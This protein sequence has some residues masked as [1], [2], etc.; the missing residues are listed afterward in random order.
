MPDGTETA[1]GRGFR[2]DRG[3]DPAEPVADA[4]RMLEAAALARP[5]HDGEAF[6]AELRTWASARGADPQVEASPRGR[7]RRLS[8]RLRR[9]S[10]EDRGVERRIDIPAETTTTVAGR[11][12]L[13]GEQ[14]RQRHRAARLGDDP[15]MAR[16][17]AIAA[18]TSASVT[19][20]PG[21]PASRSAPRVSGETS[22]VWRA[23]QRVGGAG[24]PTGTGWPAASERA[25]SSQPSGSTVD[26]PRSRA[27]RA[28]FRPTARR[29]RRGPAP[30][31]ARAPSCS[32]DLDADAPL[33]LD[34]VDIVERGDQGRPALLGEAGGDLLAALGGA[35]V[36]DDLGARGAR[37]VDASPPARRR[38]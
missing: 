6:A 22:L 16:A 36:E 29:R 2:A 17:K 35:V 11:A 27:A 9:L 4:R 13:A 12:R 18:S 31:R 24:S 3:D 38:A 8:L 20:T 1:A 7:S 25:M 19:A 37:R 28:R 34:D 33:P 15:Q 14:G 26:D 10:G 21:R 5:G 30:C 32:R 23:S